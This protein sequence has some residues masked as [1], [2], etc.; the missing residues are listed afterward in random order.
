MKTKKMTRVSF[1][2]NTLIVKLP[3][4]WTELS[5]K[6]LFEVYNIMGG[7]DRESVPTFVFQALSGM[8]VHRHLDGRF[9]C[10]FRTNEGK[11]VDVWISPE[12]LADQFDALEFLFVPGSDP[13]RLDKMRGVEAVDARL[14]GVTFG[15]YL[16]LENYFQA[17]LASRDYDLL[18]EIAGILYPGGRFEKLN[19]REKMNVLN[20]MTQIKGMF[21]LEFSHFFQ[22]CLGEAPS[23]SMVDVMNTEIRALTGGDITKESVI[24]DA[25]CR[26]ALTELDFLA[27]EAEEAK[28]KSPK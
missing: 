24:L 16:K 18:S 6:E 12:D 9:G 10:R 13:V 22:P 26:R 7:V 21:S 14:L 28:R 11:K 2:D 4:N 8:K 25:E 23:R 19:G 5:Q 15:E 1:S 27:K 3:K 20:W 17:F